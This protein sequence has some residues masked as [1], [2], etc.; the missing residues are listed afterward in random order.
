MSDSTVANIQAEA[1]TGV[2]R[3]TVV[4]KNHNKEEPRLYP[5]NGSADAEGDSGDEGTPKAVLKSIENF[6]APVADNF[7][8]PDVAV[9]ADKK[10][11][12]AQPGGLGVR[13][14]SWIDQT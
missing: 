12:V 9:H 3:P 11:S 2:E 5:D 10:R 8:K 4:K 1:T 14:N 6:F 7:A 13:G